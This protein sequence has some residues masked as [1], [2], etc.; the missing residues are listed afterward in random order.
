MS[1]LSAVDL[2]KTY[3]RIGKPAVRAI[4][5]VSLEVGGAST[6]GL[7]GESGAGKSTILR[8]LLGL[9]RPDQGEIIFD[10]VDI[11]TL[12]GHQLTEYRRQVQVVFQDPAGSLNPRMTVAQLV[13]E[14]MSVH[15]R[16]EHRRQ[17]DRVAELLG[18]V[19]LSA[20]VMDRRPPSF[21]GGQLQR[22]AIARALAVEPQ[23]LICDEPVSALDVSVQAQILN[24]LADM[25]EELGLSILLVSHNLAVIRYLCSMIFVLQHGRIVES[26][27]RQ[28]IFENP[29]HRYTRDLLA[30]VPRQRT[31]E[32]A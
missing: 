22:I 26:G 3:K 9:E 24:L 12:K 30:A 15:H 8:C 4:D 17:R 11:S 29:Q 19:G 27:S 18:Q 20:D 5:H 16:V 23:L 13:S 2:C 1:M 25:R 7:V 14:G 28:E 32:V 31:Q 10:G 6:V 21:S